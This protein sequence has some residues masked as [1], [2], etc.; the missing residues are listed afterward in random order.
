MAIK[1]GTTGNDTLTGT[2]GADTLYGLE[3]NDTLYGGAGNDI[4]LGR[5]GDDVLVGGGGADSLN[6]G[7]GNDTFKYVAFKDAGGD[8][9]VDFAAGDRIDFSAIAGRTF[10]GNAQFNGVAGEIR[11]YGDSAYTYVQI[12]ADGD[13]SADYKITVTGRFNFAQTAAGSGILI[14]AA[15]KTLSGTANADVLVGGMGN[16]ALWGLDG[17]DTLNGGTGHDKLF[18]GNGADTLTGG[19]GTDIYTGGAGNDLFRFASPDEINGDTLADF[20]GDR[21]AIA[22]AG[23]RYIGDRS[24]T[25]GGRRVPLRR[26]PDRFRF[27]WRHGCRPKHL[28]ERLHGNAAG[29][30][31]WLQHPGGC[32][33]QNPER[34]GR[35]R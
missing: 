11:Y 21:I 6:G 29:N 22:I 17:N 9:L 12:D 4:L 19:L 14:A 16:D 34:Y 25:G 2:S 7:M 1:L 33:E 30:R 13:A 20:A 24:F 32:A 15:N 10:I 27:R 5:E 28:R 23:L 18:G 8:R 3:G 26:R 35:Q 31:R